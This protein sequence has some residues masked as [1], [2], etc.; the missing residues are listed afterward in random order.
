MK[1]QQ[2]TMPTQYVLTTGC[3]QALVSP[4][5]EGGTWV[6]KVQQRGNVV[7]AAVFPELLVAQ[8]WCIVQ[9]LSLQ[10]AGPGQ[11]TAVHGP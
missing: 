2:R 3:F 4:S 8:A 1:W 6:S 11:L 5:L 10:V 9:I 7:R